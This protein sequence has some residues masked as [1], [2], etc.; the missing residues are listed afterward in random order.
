M[1]II[2]KVRQ[3]DTWEGRPTIELKKFIPKHLM[4]F[5]G[6]A[7]FGGKETDDPIQDAK[8]WDE[9]NN[10]DGDHILIIDTQVPV[11]SEYH[12]YCLFPEFREEN[13]FLLTWERS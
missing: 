12:S 8:N 1:A 6:S 11:D 7:G 13:D 10:Q 2:A 4:V 3:H 5:E 9:A